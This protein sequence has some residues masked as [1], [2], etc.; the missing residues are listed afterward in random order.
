MTTD[1]PP[2]Q[3]LEH[4]HAAVLRRAQHDRALLDLAVANHPDAG[5]LA[6]A[7]DCRLGQCRTRRRDRSRFLQEPHL[8]A[9]VRQDA[10]VQLVEGDADTN[11]G[12]LPVGGRHD[13]DHVARDGPVGIRVE[14]RPDF[15]PVADA[16]DVGLVDVHLDLARVHVHD[17]RDARA[18]E[19]AARRHRRNRLAR[20]RVLG[21]HDSRKRGAD[22]EV[23][24][25][26]R[27]ERHPALRHADLSLRRRKTRLECRDLG[28]RRVEHTLR[29]ELA[30]DEAA[31]ARVGAPCVREP[32]LDLAQ[33][34]ARCLERLVRDVVFGP[35]GRRIEP[36]EHLPLLYARALLD[37]NL[38]HASSDLGTHGRQAPGHDIAGRVEHGSVGCAGGRF[39]QRGLHGHG[40][41]QDPPRNHR[42]DRRG[43]GGHDQPPEA[44]GR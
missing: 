20:L 24:Q 11:R 42:C 38:R 35:R 5:R 30:L 25:P 10:I 44:S 31:V 29:D 19:S 28:R 14:H 8:D 6:V 18:R 7:H 4:W 22:R 27:A 34:A 40:G 26:L 12:L 15:L 32:D 41:V 9:H 16:V 13:A 21:D 17:G 43:D 3:P 1:S 39:D 23:V 36:R 37:E 2:S 33:V